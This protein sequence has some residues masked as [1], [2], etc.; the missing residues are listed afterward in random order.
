MQLHR[1]NPKLRALLL[2]IIPGSMGILVMDWGKIMAYHGYYAAKT[3]TTLED[4]VR[5]RTA[6]ESKLVSVVLMFVIVAI[7][8][9]VS[10]REGKR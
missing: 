3:F 5:K 7:L 10:A 9:F 6:S 4:Y 2:N 1:L 8:G